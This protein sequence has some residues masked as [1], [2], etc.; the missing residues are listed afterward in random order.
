MQPVNIGKERDRTRK[1]ITLSE[2]V[3]FAWYFDNHKPLDY[4]E[5]E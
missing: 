4:V 2:L 3:V 1:S 5:V